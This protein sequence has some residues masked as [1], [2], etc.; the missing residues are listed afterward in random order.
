MMNKKLWTGMAVTLMAL[1]AAAASADD[2]VIEVETEYGTV[3]AIA[4]G[5][6]NGFDIGA[7]AVVYYTYAEG[8][9]PGTDGAIPTGIVTTAS[10][11]WKRP[12]TTLMRSSTAA[13]PACRTVAIA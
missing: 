13:S 8:K 1:S 9:E 5:R 11:C 4:D 6:I 10:R 12:A 2:N 7:P 3:P